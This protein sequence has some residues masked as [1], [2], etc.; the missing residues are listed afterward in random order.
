MRIPQHGALS[1][2]DRFSAPLTV[3]LPARMIAGTKCTLPAYILSLAALGW[4]D[5]GVRGTPRKVL[6]ARCE[7]RRNPC[8]G[9]L[10]IQIGVLTPETVF[11]YHYKHGP[12]DRGQ[13]DTSGCRGEAEA[14]AV[15]IPH[16]TG[17]CSPATC[18]LLVRLR[19]PNIRCLR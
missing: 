5:E 14:G 15:R 17:I 8:N 10:I 2:P 18:N 19:A 4:D 12:H 13:L 16:Q 3:R 7:T 9:F 6:G 11:Y 1:A